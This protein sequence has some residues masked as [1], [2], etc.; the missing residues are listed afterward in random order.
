MKTFSLKRKKKKTAQ[1]DEVLAEEILEIF[2]E[3]LDDLKIN[4][5]CDKR[6]SL[7]NEE[8]TLKRLKD[9]LRYEITDFICINRNL[10]IKSRV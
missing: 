1:V 5:N 2:E 6:N 7:K 9:E 4:L 3:K 10:F 8:E